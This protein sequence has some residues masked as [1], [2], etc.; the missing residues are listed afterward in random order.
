MSETLATALLHALKDRG[1]DR[2]FGIPG[3]FVLPFFRVM[4]ES[5]ILLSLGT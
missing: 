1:A 4:A 3:D 5:E 2:V